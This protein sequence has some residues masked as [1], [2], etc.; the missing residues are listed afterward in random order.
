[1]IVAM[2]LLAAVILGSCVYVFARLVDTLFFKLEDRHILVK[3]LEENAYIP[4]KANTGDAGFD[5]L[6]LEDVTVE[7]TPREE[8]PTL[9]RTGIAVAIPDGW[10][11]RIADRSSLAAKHSITCGA[12]VVDSCYRGELKVVLFN[13][14]T[15]PYD[16]KAGDRI[17][18]LVIEKVHS[19]DGV[20]EVEELPSSER[21]TGGFGSTGQ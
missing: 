17:A 13:H 7:T 8:G 2:D 19:A 1:M 15:K 9:V 16:I 10:Y 4:W 12:G 3:R 6:A 5:L 20:K 21:G 11:G 18:Q 14:G